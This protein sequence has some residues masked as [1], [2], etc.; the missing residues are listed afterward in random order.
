MASPKDLNIFYQNVNGLRTKCLELFN[1]ILINDFDII[2]ITES[3]LQ[4]DILDSEL[5]DNRYVTFRLDRNLSETG[6]C[7]GGG[8]LFFVR[9][10]IDA[11]LNSDWT[12]LNVESQCITIPARVLGSAVDLHIISPYIPPDGDLPCRVECFQR[13]IVQ[14]MNKHIHD[15][16]LILGDL[17]LSCIDWSGAGNF[18]FTHDGSRTVLDA[19]VS[20]MDEFTFCGLTQ[21]NYLAN[22]WGNV[23]D[24]CFSNLPVS[25]SRCSRPLI[26]EDAAHPSFCLSLLDLHVT[27]FHEHSEPRYNFHKCDYD[28]INIYLKH[29][30]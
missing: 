6:K 30:D 27:P 28:K 5:C 14:F 25:I 12:I 15:N 7:T 4:D 20:L 13:C 16:F 26:K 22:K 24:L 19:A 3:W 18:C 17:N 8:I 10:E 29:I 9:I 1:N 11:Y 23:L 21:Y 2:I